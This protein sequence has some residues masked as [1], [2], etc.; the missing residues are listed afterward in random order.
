[1]LA[2][3]WAVLAILPAVFAAPHG[4][5]RILLVAGAG[6]AAVV[7]VQLFVVRGAAASMVNTGML[8]HPHQVFWPLG[9]DAPQAFTDAGHGELTAPAWLQGLTRPILMA[10][11]A[12]VCAAWWVRMGGR[13]AGT[14]DVFALL[15]LVFALRCVLDPWN[16]VYY[17]LPLAL[18][19]V[20]WEVRRGVPY[21]VL[22]LAV[23]LLAWLSF[24]SYD[25][26]TGMG[27]FVLYFAWMAPLMALLGLQLF[28]APRA[29]RHPLPAAA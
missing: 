21:P 1:M 19:L 23:S 9:I 14:D 28:G 12:S 16:L 20:V 13:T 5:L 2:K 17:H 25:E 27:P 10:A 6:A 22:T 18:S 24:L 4:R 3:Q 7:G 29:P 26:R 11:A 15:A 8:F